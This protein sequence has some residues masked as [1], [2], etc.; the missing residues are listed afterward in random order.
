MNDSN[1]PF[2]AKWSIIGNTL[3]LGHWNISYQ[4][5]P[6][7]LPEHKRS[8]DMGTDG[9][10]NFIDPEDEL[11]R[12]GLSEDD[13]I[14]ENADWLAD[15]FIEHNIPIEEQTMRHFYRAVN[16]EDWRCGSCGG[17]I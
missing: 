13:W 14:I 9:I 5:L 16:K 8:E 4:G 1:N 11:Y 10:Y 6:V 2:Q 3:C 17:C 15:V 12:E 7:M